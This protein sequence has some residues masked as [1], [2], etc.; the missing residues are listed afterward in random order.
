MSELVRSQTQG[1]TVIELNRGRAF[2]FINMDEQEG[3]SGVPELETSA[4]LD[5]KDDPK[6]TPRLAPKYCSTY[7]QRCNYPACVR[8]LAFIFYNQLRKVT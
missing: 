8:W 3:E 1:H 6:S 7:V 4:I 2:D 5:L